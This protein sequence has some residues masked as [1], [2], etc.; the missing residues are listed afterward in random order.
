MSA[1]FD[2]WFVQVGGDSY[3]PY[4]DE[5][6]ARFVAEGRVTA[7]SDISATPASGFFAAMRYDDFAR[8][9]GAQNSVQSAPVQASPGQQSPIRQSPNQQAPVSQPMTR[10]I[11][12]AELRSGHSIAFLRQL[13]A[14]LQCTRIG[15]TVWLVDGAGDTAALTAALKATLTPTDRLFIADITGRPTGQSG[16]IDHTQSA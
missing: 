10:H 16:F 4:T 7:T 5:M 2:Q 14:Y 1:V 8:W 6:M 15:D 11:V 13:Q 3:G 9:S 12:M